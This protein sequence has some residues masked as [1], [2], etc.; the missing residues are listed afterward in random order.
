MEIR[1]AKLGDVEQM[2]PVL[3]DYEIASESYLLE[4]YKYMRN[5]KSPLKECMKL[6]L[7]EQIQKKNGKF[8]VAEKE[9]KIVGYIFGEIRDDNHL[10]FDR[11]K[12][13]ELNNI[14]VLKTHQGQRISSQ[15]WAQLQDWFIENKCE[16]ITLSV[17][18][19]NSAQK[20]YKKWG[21]D[22]FYY[23]MIKKL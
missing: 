18:I 23:R 8:L 22:K 3:Q 2:I 21:F 7:Q 9:N 19:N 12:T 4:K 5:K 14:A 1:S 16:L 17:N 10:L 13:G 15:L 11:P 20:I 6:S